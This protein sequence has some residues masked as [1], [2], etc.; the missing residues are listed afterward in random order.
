VRHPR[1]P[2]DAARGAVAM[3]WTAD[4]ISSDER[5]EH[6]PVAF[7]VSGPVSIGDKYE[8]TPKRAI[9]EEEEEEEEE[10]DKR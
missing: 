9:E 2:P 7:A 1:D 8:K 6:L 10:K 5:P 3:A 4:A